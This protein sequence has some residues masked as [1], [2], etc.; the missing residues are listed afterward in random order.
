MLL[1]DGLSNAK[2]KV[3]YSTIGSEGDR[4]KKYIKDIE[5]VLNYQVLATEGNPTQWQI[6]MSEDGKEIEVICM[7]NSRVR[8][9]INNLDLLL[10]ISIVIPVDRQLWIEAMIAYRLGM[11]EL[12][13]HED[14]TAEEVPEVKK[15][16][17]V[18]FQKWIALYGRE[19]ITN[20]IDMLGCGHFA[21]YLLVCKNLYRHSQ[22]GWENINHLLKT[23]F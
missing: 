22:Q 1:I 20:Y 14:F 15:L 3:T 18:F 13:R 11:Q 7:D 9:V 5:A 2:K 16:L 19:G 23:F 8:K 21:D 6:N 17:D 12:R 10:D 4:I